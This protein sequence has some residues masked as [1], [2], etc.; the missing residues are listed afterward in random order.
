MA[1][2]CLGLAASF[3]RH[4]GD[5]SDRNNRGSSIASV[6][7]MSTRSTSPLADVD[8][9]L[10]TLLPPRRRSRRYWAAKWHIISTAFGG[11]HIWSRTS[12]RQVVNAI[13]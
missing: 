3:R 12:E 9:D 8:L 10:F 13:A 5:D 6:S 11:V 1:T 2:P 7:V 4:S